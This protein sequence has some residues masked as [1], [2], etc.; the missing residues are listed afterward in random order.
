[1]R[2]MGLLLTLPLVTSISSGELEWLRVSLS[3]DLRSSS[4][5]ASQIGAGSEEGAG[6]LQGLRVYR[7][8]LISA[9]TCVGKP[10]QCR[11]FFRSFF[12]EEPEQN[13]LTFFFHYFIA[14]AWI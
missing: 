11:L 6:K 7:L 12:L 8:N 2:E 3:V 4:L 1:M 5:S 14:K 13:V 10:P 9:Q